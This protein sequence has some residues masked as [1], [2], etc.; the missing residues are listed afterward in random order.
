MDVK[1]F[2]SCVQRKKFFRDRVLRKKFIHCLF[3]SSW[4]WMFQTFARKMRAESSK[5][6]FTYPV[7]QFEENSFLKSYVSSF[8]PDFEQEVSDFLWRDNLAERSKRLFTCPKGGFG[9]NSVWNLGFTIT[10]SIKKGWGFSWKTLER[11]VKT[12]SLL[13]TRSSWKNSHW[14]I[15]EFLL[16]DCHRKLF[17]CF[18]NFFPLVCQ[19]W[20]QELQRRI[21]IERKDFKWKN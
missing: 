7:D 6:R 20:L 9:S 18:A 4:E 13:S 14:K 17:G 3:Q 11:V 8:L 10:T 15:H 2:L 5:L 12:E 21:L 16:S 1:K 19:N